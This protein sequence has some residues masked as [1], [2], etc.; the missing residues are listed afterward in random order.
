MAYVIL[1]IRLMGF[2]IYSFI[3]MDSV[4]PFI[5]SNGFCYL[6]IHSDRFCN[7]IY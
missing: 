3:L 6:F 7:S 4:I 2:A 5:D 1:F